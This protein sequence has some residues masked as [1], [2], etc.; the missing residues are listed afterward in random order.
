MFELFTDRAK[1]VVQYAREDSK[2]RNFEYV[3]TESLLIG[4]LREPNGVAH[5]V[6]ESLDVSIG[7][8]H[9]E[10]EKIVQ[11]GPD[12]EVGDRVPFSPRAKK[13][14][15]YAEDEAKSL[16]HRYIGTE[17]LLLGLLREEESVAAQ[18]LLN[19]GIN[20]KATRTAV[21]ELLGVPDLERYQFDKVYSNVGELYNVLRVCPN[22]DKEHIAFYD[23]IA[24]KLCVPKAVELDELVEVINACKSKVKNET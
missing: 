13:M 19:L 22:G 3:G 21:L 10:I 18:I 23:S 2:K 8:I 24:K 11:A 9:I 4:L 20:V 7:R 17:H 5:H 12:Y 16:D 6:L 14:F 1:K 15:E